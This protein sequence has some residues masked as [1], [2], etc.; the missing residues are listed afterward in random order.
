MMASETLIRPPGLDAKQ[1]KSYD[2]VKMFG[3]LLDS[4]RQ[5]L[6]EGGDV[7]NIFTGEIWKREKAE[8]VSFTVNQIGRQI[9]W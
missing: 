4:T 9:V 6:V 3:R 5:I 8:R 1:V 2:A 7:R